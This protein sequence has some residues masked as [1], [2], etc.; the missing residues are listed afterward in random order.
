MNKLQFSFSAVQIRI[1]LSD[2][3][4]PP[5]SASNQAVVNV[6]IIRN[7]Q[8][9]IFFSS[10]YRVT[11]QETASIGTSVQT[12][13]ASDADTNV[14]LWFWKTNLWLS[15][16]EEL[17]CVHFSVFYFQSQFNQISYNIIGDDTAPNFFQISSSTSSGTGFSALITV[18]ASLQSEPTDFYRV[19][20]IW[21]I[22]YLNTSTGSS[23]YIAVYI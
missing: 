19:R 2:Q 21:N 8:A 11:I 17:E 9:P 7:Q 13:S 3:G 14:S 12:V 23:M 5:R 4:Q 20:R 16:D 22:E 6:T 1:S 18:R 10:E 15:W